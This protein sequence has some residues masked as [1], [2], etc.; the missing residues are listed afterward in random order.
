MIHPHFSRCWGL[1]DEVTPLPPR[2]RVTRVYLNSHRL[3]PLR[4]L[5]LSTGGDV[6]VPIEVPISR[7]EAGSQQVNMLGDILSNL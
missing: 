7:W 2:N 1:Q 4:L 6:P 5:R 3:F